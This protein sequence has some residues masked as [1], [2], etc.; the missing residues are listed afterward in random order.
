MSARKALPVSPASFFYIS[1]N[2]V[3]GVFSN[4]SPLSI[5]IYAKNANNR[6]YILA[7]L[8]LNIYFYNLRIYY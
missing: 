7:D 3:K 5:I 1:L 2:S 6:P 4:F 8:K